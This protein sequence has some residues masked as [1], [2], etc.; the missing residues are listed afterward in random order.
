[1]ANLLSL[2]GKKKFFWKLF[3]VRGEGSMET[4]SITPGKMDFL[5]PTSSS[6][7]TAKIALLPLHTSVNMSR[8]GTSHPM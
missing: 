4:H 8:N 6:G 2:L 7:G 1:M 3:T 5:W